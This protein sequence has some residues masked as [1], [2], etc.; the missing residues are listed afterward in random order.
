MVSWREYRKNYR[1]DRGGAEGGGGS[2]AWDGYCDA[3]AEELPTSI[4]GQ[5]FKLKAVDLAPRGRVRLS[6]KIALQQLTTRRHYP[7]VHRVE[8]LLNGKK[9]KLGQFVLA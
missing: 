7:G 1:G 3:P 2:C 4:D 5:T 9:V 6:K 8:A